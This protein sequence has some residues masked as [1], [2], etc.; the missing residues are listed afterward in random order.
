MT[1]QTYF[2]CCYN[3]MSARH[4][5]CYVA[6]ILSDSISC[7][8]RVST[9]TIQMQSISNPISS[10]A[11]FSFPHLGADVLSPDEPVD[12]R[13]SVHV[14]LYNVC[15]YYHESVCMKGIFIVKRDMSFCT[16]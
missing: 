16:C 2:N 4:C 8:L 10:S 13:V 6:S 12:V 9:E 3:T 7:P 15:M 14:G 11:S 5:N 1:H